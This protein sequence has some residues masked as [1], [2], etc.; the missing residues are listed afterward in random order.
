VHV[1]PLLQAKEKHGRT[2]ILILPND[3]L[4]LP[5]CVVIVALVAQ[6]AVILR[7][8]NQ[9]FMAKN[10]H[11]GAV[12]ELSVGTRGCTNYKDMGQKLKTYVQ[13]HIA[14]VNHGAQVGLFG[15][16]TYLG[17]DSGLH[18]GLATQRFDYD[19]KLDVPRGRRP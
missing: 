4:N 16:G 1:V 8:G 9:D 12:S 6:F 7:L 17:S 14:L 18:P 5:S 3:C 13:E 19:I 15:A 10:P 11:N 2:G